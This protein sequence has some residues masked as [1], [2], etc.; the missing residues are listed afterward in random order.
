M[1]VA[2]ARDGRSRRLAYDDDAVAEEEDL[3]PRND[4]D[5]PF[6]EESS[7]DE[8]RVSE[9]ERALDDDDP[10]PAEMRMAGEREPV[11][12]DDVAIAH[13]GGVRTAPQQSERADCDEQN[14]ALHGFLPIG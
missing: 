4:E 6:Y 7:L 13:P 12:E 1:P 9:E 10:R 14:A 11:M 2:A 5:P 8:V 3:A